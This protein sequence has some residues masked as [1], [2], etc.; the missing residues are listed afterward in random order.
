MF[1]IS[2]L[3][4]FGIWGLAIA[5]V[6]VVG[7]FAVGTVR[8]WVRLERPQKRIAQIVENS[9]DPEVAKAGIAAIDRIHHD[10]CAR[11]RFGSVRA[12]D[13]QQPP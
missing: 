6:L 8:A 10:E 5:V 7:A 13:G 12:P 11:P 1:I 2:A 9:P 3:A 4:P